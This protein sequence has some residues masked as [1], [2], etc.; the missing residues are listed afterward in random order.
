MNIGLAIKTIRKRLNIK[1]YELAIS[2]G[3]SHTSLCLIENAVK[4]PSHNTFDRLCQQLSI[5]PELIYIMAIEQKDVRPDKMDVY[6]RIYPL[7]SDLVMLGVSHDAE[8]S[9][10]APTG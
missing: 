7:L 3:I 8:Y 2:C 9:A 4:L 6:T 1:Q 5:P 10:C